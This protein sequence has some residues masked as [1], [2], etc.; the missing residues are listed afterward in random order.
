[1]K[2][3]Y[4]DC[5][6]GISGDMILGAFVNNL[7]PFDYLKDQLLKINLSDYQLQHN[8]T[9]RHHIAATKLDV[10][11]NDTKK[12]RHLSDIETLINES[13][14][15]QYVKEN[16]IAVFRILGKHEAKIHNIPIERVHFHEVGAIDSIVDIVGTFICLDYI[17][18]D[19]VFS[20]P[21]PLTHGTVKAAHGI[22]PVPAPATMAILEDYPLRSL[23]VSGELVTPTGAAIIKHISAGTL[24]ENLEV[25]IE[26]TGYGAGSKDFKQIPNLLRIWISLTSENYEKDSL[27][28]IETNIDNMN[29]E[30]YPYVIDKL[31]QSGANDAWLTSTI[32]KKGRPAT[33]ISVLC[34]A[35]NSEIIK[36]ILFSD[37]TTIGVRQFFVTR[38]KLKRS[39]KK[40]DSPWGSIA[41]KEI[42][43]NGKRK[44]VAEYEE[45]RRLAEDS[46]KTI[47]KMYEEVNDFL[48]NQNP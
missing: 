2:L 11:C 25:K 35:E 14:L 13:T 40:I 20:S 33:Q 9:H 1:M 21:L 7:V 27:I 22:L 44:L 34:R 17:K 43:Y 12:S 18:A 10:I 28:Q 38:D 23:D 41:V 45:C 19:V 37:T 39:T 3:L 46:G 24:P 8:D 47:T 42:T 32:M 48:K 5:F 30:I 36:S 4:F 31:L 6:A 16:S 15:P 26:K 29:P